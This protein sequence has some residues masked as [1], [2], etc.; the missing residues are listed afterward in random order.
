[1]YPFI[2]DEETPTWYKIIVIIAVGFVCAAF[3]F[4]IFLKVSKNMGS[5]PI[6]LMSKTPESE[7]ILEHEPLENKQEKTRRFPTAPPPTRPFPPIPHEPL[8]NKQRKYKLSSL[9][10]EYTKT[11]GKQTKPI[12]RIRKQIIP[13]TTGEI[14]KG[15]RA[16][17]DSIDPEVFLNPYTPVSG[18]LK[19]T[20]IQKDKFKF[21]SEE[22]S[23]T[24]ISPIVK[25]SPNEMS[26]KKSHPKQQPQIPKNL[27]KSELPPKLVMT[28]SKK[29]KHSE[30]IKKMQNE[31]IANFAL[32]AKTPRK[33]PYY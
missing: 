3:V 11:V 19:A 13:L 24:S 18:G 7:K 17:S 14:I 15:Y 25:N 27:R 9:E 33:M 16:K 29:R 6:G 23:W 5:Y 21:P 10:H 30:N 31:A 28:S 26:T 32:D 2:W 22:S 12:L 1:M 8:E 4:L 20:K